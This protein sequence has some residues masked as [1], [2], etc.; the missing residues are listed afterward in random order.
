MATALP[1]VRSKVCEA[2]WRTFVNRGF[3][4]SPR[5]HCWSWQ[6][7]GIGDTVGLAK[8]ESLCIQYIFILSCYVTFQAILLA[9]A[10]CSSLPCDLLTMDAGNSTWIF[11]VSVWVQYTN[12]LKD[13]FCQLWLFTLHLS[14]QPS[15]TLSNCVPHLFYFLPPPPPPFIRELTD[16]CSSTVSVVTSNFETV[17]GAV[18]S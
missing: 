11:P 18:P 7:W 8:Y 16:I 15:G 3:A 2:F 13:T 4:G 1:V 5:H 12:F 10:V 6:G 14:A 17:G 9:V